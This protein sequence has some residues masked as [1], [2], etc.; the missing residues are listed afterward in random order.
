MKQV[1]QLGIEVYVGLREKRLEFIRQAVFAEDIVEEK[2]ELG[3]K[4]ILQPHHPLVQ[5]RSPDLCRCA[6]KP[7]LLNLS[8]TEPQFNACKRLEL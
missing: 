5:L 6:H 4:D 8:E 7:K 2:T 1:C 3:N